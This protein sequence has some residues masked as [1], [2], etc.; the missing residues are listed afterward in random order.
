MA[1]AHSVSMSA[2]GTVNS[3]L[4]CEVTLSNVCV[5]ASVR[6]DVTSHVAVNERVIVKHL[7]FITADHHLH[8]P[9]ALLS[10]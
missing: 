9:S 5:P 1:A 6:L 7:Y 10:D 8:K 4:K 2:V 3:D